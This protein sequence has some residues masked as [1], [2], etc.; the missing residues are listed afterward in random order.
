MSV[1]TTCK[2]AGSSHKKA[3]NVPKSS[4]EE[5]C[6]VSPHPKPNSEETC[7]AQSHYFASKQAAISQ[8]TAATFK[9]AAP[10]SLAQRIDR[11]FIQYSAFSES[12]GSD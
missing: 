8:Q 6:P 2:S 3:L 11:W 4:N 7:T 5:A 1:V 12:M 9:A 10:I